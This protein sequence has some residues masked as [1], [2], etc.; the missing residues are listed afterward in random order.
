MRSCSIARPGFTGGDSC[1]SKGDLKNQQFAF[2][3][4]A[5]A[6]RNYRAVLS[7]RDRDDN[8]VSGAVLRSLEAIRAGLS[9][10][11]GSGARR[12]RNGPPTFRVFFFS[13]FYW[14]HLLRTRI[15]SQEKLPGRV[16]GAG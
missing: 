14:Y 6:I 3:P 11:H 5:H 2:L 15:T 7:S 8:A 4:P 9:R 1:L 10:V 16:A 12:F 13:L